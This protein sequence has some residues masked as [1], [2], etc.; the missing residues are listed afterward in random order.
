MVAPKAL[1]GAPVT[2]TV[3][4]VDLHKYGLIVNNVHNPLPSAVESIIQLKNR[5]GA[6][7]FTNCYGSRVM[8][9]SGE[10]IADN[11]D[12]LNNN[13]DGLNSLFRLKSDK[14]GIKVIFSDKSDRV[15][16]CRYSSFDVQT[17][18]LKNYGRT[19]NYTLTLSCLKPWSE[20]TTPRYGYARISINKN[21]HIIY[22]G[23]MRT[24][25]NYTMLMGHFDGRINYLDV[26][27]D[28]KQASFW[29]GSN[30]TIGTESDPL[31]YDGNCVEFERVSDGSFKI[32]SGQLL[33]NYVGKSDPHVLIAKVRTRATITLRVVYD[34][35][36]TREKTILPLE[37]NQYASGYMILYP[38]D[39]EEASQL[40][41]EVDV[42]D[43][44]EDDEVSVDSVALYR[45][46]DLFDQD[47]PYDYFV[48]PPYVGYVAFLKNLDLPKL[49]L[50]S[51]NNIFPWKTSDGLAGFWEVESNYEEER[52]LSIVKDP[53]G[54][55]PCLLFYCRSIDSVSAT[56]PRV[57]VTKLKTY[58]IFFETM[59][60]LFEKA[61]PVGYVK[62][63]FY[64]R[65]ETGNQLMTESQVSIEEANGVW[66]RHFIK[67]EDL[68][69][70]AMFG[71]FIIANG[72][73]VNSKVFIKNILIVDELDPDAPHEEY[74]D[75]V[76]QTQ[77]PG[78]LSNYKEE[79]QVNNEN[80][81]V[82]R[83]SGNTGAGN[84]MSGFAGDRFI[85]SPGKNVL[86][87]R[88]A[89]WSDNSNSPV[90]NPEQQSLGTAVIIYS[91]TERYL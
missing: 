3:D 61:G 2:I 90:E 88:D 29:S 32:S 7:D 79:V 25:L 12:G 59:C 18:T 67:V 27:G 16:T 5:D 33:L 63:V 6:F 11:H 74:I 22:S 23:T 40:Q 64:V 62:I 44:S 21:L 42:L 87:L 9:I 30:C 72:G 77:S 4:G 60:T 48:P 37:L 57:P 69:E 13:I 35:N 17:K 82:V 73:E 46:N 85:L 8:T 45:L 65:D 39:L 55:K 70:G 34:G 52:V 28:S 75:P 19:A 1:T 84:G 68:P 14:T 20:S 31:A 81:V 41:I 38:E 10:I 26:L 47:Y 54:I 51:S 78:G 49:T 91:Y 76:I 24:P 15:W 71:E 50:S 80:M 43:D 83:F 36:I 58:R 86:S 53:L 66:E 89:R 56:G